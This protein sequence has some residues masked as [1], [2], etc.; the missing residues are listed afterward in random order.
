MRSLTIDFKEIALIDRNEEFISEFHVHQWFDISF[1][2]KGAVTYEID[3]RLY[4]V[5]EG[6]VVVVPPGKPHKEIC[7]SEGHFEVL[8]VCLSFLREGLPVN[9]SEHLELPEVIKIADLKGIYGIFEDI[10]NEVTY[11]NDGYLLKI[12]AQ[13]YNLIVAICRNHEALG[14]NIDSIKKLSNLRK[15]KIAEEIKEF[16]ENNYSRKIS[17]NEL[18]RNFF[19]SPQYISSIFKA[20][21][22]YTPIEYLNRV[23]IG[24]AKE[25]F[26]AGLDNIG[27]V[28]D[29]V[30]IGDIH[31]FYKVFKQFEKK[32]PVQF[33]ASNGK[34]TL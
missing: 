13:V 11:R 23:R 20:Y 5:S 31:Y 26:A 16:M 2:M 1:V 22:G 6:E 8:F 19:L 17:L 4:H 21:T 7:C 12:N 34:D 9:I 3:S 24:K 25:F 29:K 15:H 10:L 28:A 18:S 14:R 27:E 32:T 30:G 33:I